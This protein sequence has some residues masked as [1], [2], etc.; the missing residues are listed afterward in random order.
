M[1]RTLQK[2]E[3]SRQALESLVDSEPRA[4]LRALLPTLDG[5][6]RRGVR[7]AEMARVLAEQGIEMKPESVRRAVDRWR[8]TQ[9]EHSARTSEGQTR[10]STLSRQSPPQ[11]SPA[12]GA[13]TT[14]GARPTAAGIPPG[15]PVREY[16]RQLRNAPVDPD[17]EAR[18]DREWRK[19]RASQE[20][21]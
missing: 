16:L 17:E 8:K 11:L 3:S 12:V 1:E 6:A 9:A 13:L 21:A 10:P 20:A 18:R 15:V 14:G 5:L 2:I 19:T 4:H 7:Y